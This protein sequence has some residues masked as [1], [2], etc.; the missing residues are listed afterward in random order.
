MNQCKWCCASIKIGPGP[1]DRA[2]WNRWKCDGC[3]AF[4]YVNDP[5][6]EELE[7]I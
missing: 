2:D 5:D 1:D 7:L 6:P 4:G 3:G